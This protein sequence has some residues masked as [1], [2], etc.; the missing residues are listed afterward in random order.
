MIYQQKYF[1]LTMQVVHYRNNCLKK[2]L[3]LITLM[4]KSNFTKRQIDKLPF[5]VT[6]KRQCLKTLKKSL[7]LQKKSLTKRSKRLMSYYIILNYLK[8]TKKERR[9]CQKLKNLL[10]EN[11]NLFKRHTKRKSIKQSNESKIKKSHQVLL[12][13]TIWIQ[14][15]L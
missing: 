9:I 7:I 4:K 1:E 12:S 3:K 10:K 15:S 14:E 11:L 6:I 5:C 8:R 2:K 13:L